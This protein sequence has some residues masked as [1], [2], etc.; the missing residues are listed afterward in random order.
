MKDLKV[1]VS[2]RLTEAEHAFISTLDSWSAQLGKA[3]LSVKREE[4]WKLCEA[5]ASHGP[6]ISGPQV[7]RTSALIDV[8]AAQAMREISEDTGLSTNWLISLFLRALQ[9]GSV[10]VD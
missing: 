10:K 7:K 5:V 1:T 2:V 8:T 9:T 3:V 6:I 4:F